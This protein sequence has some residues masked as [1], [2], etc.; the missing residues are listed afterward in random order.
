PSL[1]QAVHFSV[2]TPVDGLVIQ[3][4]D[5]FQLSADGISFSRF[6]VF[7]L[8][9]LR[10]G[11]QTLYVQF[12]PENNILAVLD[13]L[14]LT[15][16][17]AAA[18]QTFF[19]QGDTFSRDQTLDIVN[20]NI[21]WFGS[22]TTGFGPAD[23]DLAQANIKKIMDSLN[24]DVY[25][26]SEVVDT[27]R[28]SKLIASMPEYG[29]KLTDYCSG[30]ASNNTA[31]YAVGQKLAFVYRKSI[32]SN[33]AARGM[34]R[35]S[36]SARV[37][38]ANGR[39]PFLNEATFNSNLGGAKINFILLHGKSGNTLADHQKR[40]DATKELKDSLDLFF[41]HMPLVILGD[42]NDDLDTA[43]T[44][45]IS[46]LPSAYASFVNDSVGLSHYKAVSFLL[47][48]TGSRTLSSYPDP[49]DHIFLSDELKQTYLDGSVRVVYETGKWVKNYTTTTS[50]HYPVISRLKMKAGTITSVSNPVAATV[51]KVM[52]AGHLL[53]LSA[54]MQA[55]NVAIAAYTLQGELLYSKDK[56]S[57]RAGLLHHQIDVSRWIPGTYVLRVTA[58][59]K[60]IA[61]RI[62][63]H[64]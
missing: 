15:G 32:F 12:Y 13:T 45:G 39:F 2:Q 56:I 26:F 43:I 22:K 5:F 3:A 64:P 44:S 52:Q 54:S 28:F 14:Q 55:V 47:S 16:A 41:K 17:K 30:A 33:I 60:T 57:S 36:E 21:E 49:V 51:V 59:G 58:V 62:F 50:D 4:P 25:A 46:A 20:W 19:L 8:E 31:A 53:T 63:I 24:A 27:L 35:Q 1:K 34:L 38:W 48:R 23:D 6:A 11:K 42:F 61:L 18:G 9:Q 7:P 37:N 10:K 40:V 29:Y